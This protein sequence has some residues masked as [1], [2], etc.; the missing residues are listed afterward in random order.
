MNG[1]FLEE[2]PMAAHG[3]DCAAAPNSEIFKKD[4]P[5][6]SMKFSGYFFWNHQ[7]PGILALQNI[8]VHF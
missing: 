2:S 6:L 8:I 5:L 1:G 4:F 7:R 3:R